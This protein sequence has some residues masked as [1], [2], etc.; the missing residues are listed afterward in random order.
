MSYMT[1]MT[2]YFPYITSVLLTTCFKPCFRKL[3]RSAT[4]R[5][6]GSDFLC[7]HPVGDL[8]ASLVSDRN[9]AF[10]AVLSRACTTVWRC[11]RRWVGGML[12]VVN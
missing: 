7:W 12:L 10:A 6:Q 1:S 8:V 9:L 2:S 5:R 3:S 11:L 4:G